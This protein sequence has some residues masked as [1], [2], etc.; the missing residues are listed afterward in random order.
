MAQAI[1]ADGNK[2]VLQIHHAGREATLRGESGL[3]V[4][5]PSAI[6]F[7][8]LDYPVEELTTDHIKQI[9][10]DFYRGRQ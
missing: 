4:Y 6:D 8:F 2:A 3:P 7:S 10:Q 5:E 9:V 1:K